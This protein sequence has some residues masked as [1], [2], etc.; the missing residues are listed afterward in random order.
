[1]MALVGVEHEAFV[2]EPDTY[3]RALLVAIVTDPPKS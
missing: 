2:S 3:V 1:M